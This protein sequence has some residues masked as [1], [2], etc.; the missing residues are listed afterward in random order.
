MGL[1]VRKRCFITIVIDPGLPTLIILVVPVL[2][3]ALY[4]F[5]LYELCL[6]VF[7]FNKMNSGGKETLQSILSRKS[8][9]IALEKY[10]QKNKCNGNKTMLLS[11]SWLSRCPPPSLGSEE[12]LV[13]GQRALKTD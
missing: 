6:L 5:F 1:G 4:L 7:L 13:G 9:T 10:R 11:C 2:W 12:G 8:V 3:C